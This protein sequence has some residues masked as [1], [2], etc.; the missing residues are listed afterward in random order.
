MVGDARFVDSQYL[1]ARCLQCGEGV[2]RQFRM[3]TNTNGGFDNDNSLLKSLY[4]GMLK[5][6]ER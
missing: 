4:A 5:A 3:L 2:R 1:F 6:S